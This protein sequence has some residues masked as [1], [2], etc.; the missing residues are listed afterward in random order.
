MKLNR[1]WLLALAP[2]AVT[3]CSD[4][5]ADDVIGPT[6]DI[7]FNEEE[8]GRF[9]FEVYDA[10]FDA[11][12][13]KA[14]FITLNAETSG[15]ELEGGFLLSTKNYRSFPW[16]FSPDYCEQPLAAQLEKEALDTCRYSVYT[17]YGN[18]NQTYAVAKVEGDKAFFTLKNADTIEHILVANTTY[19]YLML[20]YG[21]YYSSCLNEETQLYEPY[22]YA[23]NGV[24]FDTDSPAL[25]SNPKIPETTAKGRFYL[26]T[27]DD[28]PIRSLTGESNLAKA[29]AKEAAIEK[30]TTEGLSELEI[31]T[32]GSEAESNAGAG[33]FKLIIKG[34]L[35]GAQVGT[36]EYYM[37]A[38][39]NAVEDF[40]ALNTI[41]NE[42]YKVDLS[43]LG[44][45]DKVVFNLDSSDKDGEGNMR[46]PPYFCL[47]GI[48][49]A[50]RVK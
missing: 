38:R 33:W 28:E 48:R 21:S 29:A 16:S 11:G 5:F 46:T 43:S 3:A 27:C 24:D 35:D 26:P 15:G 39:T 4:K 49:L 17:N 42:W 50:G 40:P 34:Y 12:N 2:F 14:G 37:G 22:N 41:K 47:D 45:V 10:P 31:M 13:D 44:K 25:V 19:N 1:I 8:I 23:A 6:Y 36:V 32:A 18:T 20:T 30:A 9:T 7:T